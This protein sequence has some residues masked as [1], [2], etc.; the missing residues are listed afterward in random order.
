MKQPEK[1][2]RNGNYYEIETAEDAL[3]P[4]RA[5]KKEESQSNI[6]IPPENIIT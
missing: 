3:Y 2:V 6:Y 1:V 4:L 5:N